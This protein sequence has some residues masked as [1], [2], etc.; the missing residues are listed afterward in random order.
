MYKKKPI[1]WRFASNS[2]SVAKSASKVL[3][4]M[5]RMSKFTVQQIRN[6]YLHSYIAYLRKE[7][8]HLEK[9]EASLNC[10]DANKLK[11]YRWALTEC[12]DYDEI[13]KDLA[14]QQK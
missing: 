9:E 11:E 3:V 2:E 1:Y 14:N 13:I 12:R 6:K 10:Q 4:Y 7:I 8:I 5:H